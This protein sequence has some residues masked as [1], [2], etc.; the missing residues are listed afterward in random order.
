MHTGPRK[1]L[2][3]LGEQGAVLWK[4]EIQ[5]SAFPILLWKLEIQ[6]SVFP[7]L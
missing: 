4:L 6:I 2:L 3:A 1:D 7:I 5:I